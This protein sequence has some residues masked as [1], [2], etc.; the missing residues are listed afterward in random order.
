MRPMAEEAKMIVHLGYF[1]HE[2]FE[3]YVSIRLLN[4]ESE[5]PALQGLADINQKTYNYLLYDDPE[6]YLLRQIE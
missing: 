2:D 4:D 6:E 1:Q 3:H 5:L